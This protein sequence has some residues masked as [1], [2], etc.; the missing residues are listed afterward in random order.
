MRPFGF[1]SLLHS[2]NL[3]NGFLLALV[4]CAKLVASRPY[5]AVRSNI[6]ALGRSTTSRRSPKASTKPSIASV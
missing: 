4:D 6:A 5:A 3:T 1:G 2:T